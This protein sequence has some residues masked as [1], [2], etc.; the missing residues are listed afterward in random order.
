[1]N[2]HSSPSTQSTAAFLSLENKQTIDVVMVYQDF[3]TGLRAKRLYDNLCRQ[4][5]PECELNQSMWKF[6]VLAIPRI[7]AVAAEEAAEADLVIISMH[8]DL[9][10]PGKVKAWLE[11]WVGDKSNPN[12]AL[13][14][15]FDD[16][17]DAGGQVASVQASLRQIADRGGM[18]FFADPASSTEWDTELAPE[19]MRTR[20]DPAPAVWASG[21][22]YDPPS[23]HWG[24]NE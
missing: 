19:R 21:F 13:V 1:M 17:E 11:T 2:L 22:N 18:H 8:G 6:E 16:S 15:V 10:L 5:E 3:A 14:A 24:I 23:R 12:G 4:L 20:I 7:G 9:E